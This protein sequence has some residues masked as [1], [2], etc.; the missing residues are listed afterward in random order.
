MEVGENR[1]KKIVVLSMALLLVMTATVYGQDLHSRWVNSKNLV[2]YSTYDYRW[3]D[4]MGEGVR[5][6]MDDF[7]LV[8]LGADNADPNGWQMTV[9]T[10]DAG[11][12]TMT[13]GA[14]SAGA[15]IL[16]TDG[17]ENDGLNLAVVGE[18][19]LLTQNAPLYFG[20]KLAVSDADATD[21]F[22]GLCITD[23]E[24]WGGIS[25]GVYFLSAD[26][27]AV[28][29]FATEKDGTATTD[30]SA[31]TLTDNVYHVLEFTWDG[32]TYI[33]AYFD[34]TLVATSST[35]IPNDEALTFALEYLTGETAAN[36]VTIDWIRIIQ[37]R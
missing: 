33:K 35:N 25:D 21:L 7:T 15:L 19:F 36:T 37:C 2:Y 34:G 3:V 16:T 17:T 26:A 27:T 23:T 10:G 32:S 24:M 22:V 8:P 4:A 14:D 11:T 20:I 29:S 18:V 5:K 28:C 1:M 6:F 12:A 9:L 13:A 30:A 31:G